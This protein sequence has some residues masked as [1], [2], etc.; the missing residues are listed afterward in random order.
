M[1]TETDTY[2][3][4][5]T[6]AQVRVQVIAASDPQNRMLVGHWSTPQ[7]AAGWNYGQAADVMLTYNNSRPS[8]NWTVSTHSDSL[9]QVVPLALPW[10]RNEAR[11]TIGIHLCRGSKSPLLPG[12]VRQNQLTHWLSF[13]CCLKAADMKFSVHIGKS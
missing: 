10:P 9:E 3:Y 4:G 2:M 8:K 5:V 6:K 12:Q 1:D 11:E 13:M 7:V